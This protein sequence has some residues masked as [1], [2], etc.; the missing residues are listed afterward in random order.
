MKR[1]P[2]YFWYLLLI[3]IVLGCKQNVK[4]DRF[5]FTTPDEKI[6]YE[7]M[8]ERCRALSDRNMDRLRQIYSET[9]QDLVWITEKVIP[10]LNQWPARYR[11]LKTEKLSIIDNDAAGRFEISVDNGYKYSR[12]EVDVLY[13]KEDST[14]KIESV[15]EL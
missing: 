1:F 14:W 3:L 2:Q 6:L 4:E 13:I 5:S 7:L 15:I 9:S 11:I 10:I 12:K 8:A